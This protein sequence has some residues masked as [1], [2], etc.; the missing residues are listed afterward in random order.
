MR[1]EAMRRQ[2]ESGVGVDLREPFLRVPYQERPRMSRLQR[3]HGQD[4]RAANHHIS[5]PNV[6]AI[7]S[8][9]FSR[10]RSRSLARQPIAARVRA[11]VA[12]RR[13]AARQLARER[14]EAERMA[15]EVGA[16]RRR[17]TVVRHGDDEVMMMSGEP[18]DHETR[19]G[20]RLDRIIVIMTSSW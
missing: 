17:G 8:A 9:L 14:R 13:R 12:A 19:R 7:E 4:T 20:P 18:R 3:H 1:R 5:Q 2:R 10:S 6:S 11:T 16:A 15:A